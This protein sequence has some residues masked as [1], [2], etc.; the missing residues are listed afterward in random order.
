MISYNML[1]KGYYILPP[2]ARLLARRIYYFPLDF[3][4]WLTGRRDPLT[5]PRG[6]IYTGRGDFRKQGKEIL[7][8]L[9]DHGGLKPDHSVLDVGSGIGRV[10][11]ALTGYLSGES[12]Y[13]GFD[14]VKTGVK[15]CKRKISNRF[16]LDNDLYRTSGMDAGHFRFPYPKEAFDM[17]VVVSVFTH[18]LPEE[19]ENYYREIN[20]VLKKGGNVFA[21]FFLLNEESK[22]YMPHHKGFSFPHSHGHFSLMDETVKSANVAFEEGY[23]KD[24][25]LDSGFEIL[26]LFY[27]NW[28]DPKNNERPFFQDILILAKQ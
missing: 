23:I 18:M 20:R 9:I 2:W 22:A 6:L 7:N 19:V 10:A 8:Y 16:P 17:V 4:D 27:G 25:V 24:M 13:E 15:W 28:S 14:V 21:T 1:R 5:P 26:H 11:V 3:F 12:R